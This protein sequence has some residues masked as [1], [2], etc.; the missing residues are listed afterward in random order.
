MYHILCQKLGGEH[1]RV[2]WISI[3]IPEC[4]TPEQ[5][6]H[7]ENLKQK[8]NYVASFDSAE[9]ARQYLDQCAFENCKRYT[10]EYIENG[11]PEN[12]EPYICRQVLAFIG[13]DITSYP[14]IYTISL[15]D[16]KIFTKTFSSVRLATIEE[17]DNATRN[18]VIIVKTDVTNTI[19]D[20]GLTETTC[21]NSDVPFD[22]LSKYKKIHNDIYSS[23]FNISIYVYGN[24]GDKLLEYMTNMYSGD[25][26]IENKLMYMLRQIKESLFHFK[27]QADVLEKL[28]PI[29]TLYPST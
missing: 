5:K 16:F 29:L 4:T 17:V 24:H 21:L 23:I 9:D 11:F 15:F 26:I 8:E 10:K 12:I 2:N 22:E 3:Q 20:M 28:L 7:I 27:S 19:K 6:M 25:Q 13:D 1:S 18:S 14:G